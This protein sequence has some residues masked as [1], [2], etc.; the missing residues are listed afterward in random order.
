MK[1]LY[2]VDTQND[3]MMSDGNLSVPDAMDIIPNLKT[4][5]DHFVEMGY[6][7]MGSVDAHTGPEA[8]FPLHCIKGTYG[9]EKIAETDGDIVYVSD[10]EYT[11]EA[12]D[13]IVDEAKDG[14][15]IYFEKQDT[16]V[17][18]NPNFEP[19]MKKLGVEEAYIMG[20]AT[21][22]C[23]KHADDAFKELGIKTYLVE[24]AI[25]GLDIPGCTEQGE[26]D[27]MLMTGTEMYRWK[28]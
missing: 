15:R 1:I 14:R 11:S 7:V 20:V 16:S 4:T 27:E 24:G 26:L 18:D 8:N 6:N 21:N 3:F 28:T 23:V 19:M 25:K 13:M 12:L 10:H 9:Q 5:I 2:D 17:F 22:I